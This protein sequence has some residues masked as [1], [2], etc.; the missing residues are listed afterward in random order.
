[1]SAMH[2]DAQ[3]GLLKTHIK[4]LK[5][6]VKAL[7]KIEAFSFDTTFSDADM[8]GVARNMVQVASDALKLYRKTKKE[9]PEDLK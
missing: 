3:V 1:M 6:V 7:E 8:R 4:E 2:T 5:P 9:L